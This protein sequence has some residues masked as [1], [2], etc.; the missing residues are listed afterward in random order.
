[1]VQRN[2]AVRFANFTRDG[3]M[4]GNSKKIAQITRASQRQSEPR[5]VER[6][7]V[8]SRSKR[9]EKN[10]QMETNTGV[11][12]SMTQ[13]FANDDSVFSEH[14]SSGSRMAGSQGSDEKASEVMSLLGT[15]DKMIESSLANVSALTRHQAHGAA[16]ASQLVE[17]ADSLLELRFE[18]ASFAAEVPA[19]SR[20]DL[21]LK[22]KL[23]EYWVGGEKADPTDQLAKSLCDDVR[24]IC[25][26]A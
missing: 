26:A 19:R 12:S 2:D 15:V 14:R 7:N 21:A 23:L 13:D 4:L 11:R 8:L 5:N 18:I 25:G 24:C 9:S 16:R 6:A 17:I 1:M 20:A 3:S 22:A 10:L